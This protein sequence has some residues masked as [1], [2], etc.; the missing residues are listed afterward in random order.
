[1][2]D[3]CE[4]YCKYSKDYDSRFPKFMSV[5]LHLVKG[6]LRPSKALV[7]PKMNLSDFKP[8]HRR[9]RK[10]GMMLRKLDIL[11]L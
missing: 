5:K 6:P 10:K 1:M 11:V 2:K 8:R 3:F 7:F 4:L 9:Q